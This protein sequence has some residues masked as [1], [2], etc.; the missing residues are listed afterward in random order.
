MDRPVVVS[1]ARREPAAPSAPPAEGPV[2]RLWAWLAEPASL[3]L[4]LG[5]RIRAYAWAVGLTLASVPFLHLYIAVPLGTGE[6]TWHALDI[7]G[8]AGLAA[9]GIEAVV[10][11]QQRRR[12]WLFSGARGAL[13]LGAVV[14]GAAAI[15]FAAHV[16]DWLPHSGTIRAKHEASG[17]GDMSLRVWPMTLL[18]AWLVVQ[19]VRRDL[20][21]RELATLR[22]IERALRQRDAAPPPARPAQEPPPILLRHDGG[23]ER[24]RPADILCV[25]AQENYCE[26]V[27][28]GKGATARPAA[29]RPWVRMTLAQALES[30]PA[31][32]FV[33]TH[34][35]HIANL[36]RVRAIRREGRRCELLLDG[37]VA[38]PVS[39]GR[40]AQVRARVAAEAGAD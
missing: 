38:V 11:L 28:A 37:G 10:G 16:H 34:R 13:L 6:L 30:L 23:E 25:Q 1:P 39:R 20:L 2:G 24:V 33:Q 12:D 14:L 18:I 35:S 32:S 26:F 21:T 17:Y 9:A 29:P 19:A 5:L 4:R 40:L 31:S 15:A 27:L 8:G 22:G 3:D 36:D 7:A